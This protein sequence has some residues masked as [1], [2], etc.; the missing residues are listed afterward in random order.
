MRTPFLIPIILSLFFCHSLQGQISGRVSSI[1]GEAL[2][3]ASIYV[4]NTSIGTSSNIEGDYELSLA[5]GTYQLVFQYIGYQQKVLEISV[6]QSPQQLDVQLKE[7]S[8]TLSEVVVR[9]DA[10]D[11]AYPIIRKAIAKR[12]YYKNLVNAYSCDAYI[13]GVQKLL[14]APDK[15]LG[16]EI[17]DMGGSLDSN[18]QGIVYLSES[19]AQLFYQRPNQKKEV[20]ISSKVSGNDYC[21]S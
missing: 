17:G 8:V 13:K 5:P 6:D 4:Q 12:P 14:D 1:S 10:E 16:Q 19:E 9:A 7:E 18:R 2:A 15:V 20:M 21:K 11:P 3:F